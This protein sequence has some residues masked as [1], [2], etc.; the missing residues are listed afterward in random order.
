MY[1]LK[2]WA[3]RRGT[4]VDKYVDVDEFRTLYYAFM[5]VRS[6]RGHNLR[7][8]IGHNHDAEELQLFQGSRLEMYPEANQ[9][10]V[11]RWI[12][13]SNLEWDPYPLPEPEAE[14]VDTPVTGSIEDL[15]PMVVE[16][17]RRVDVAAHKLLRMYPP[18]TADEDD[19]TFQPVVSVMSDFYKVESSDITDTFLTL[20][21]EA[22][23]NVAEA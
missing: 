2:I 17:R 1:Y 10:L 20:C 13:L 12:P 3:T 23:N 9:E 6:H 22:Q 16:Y 18:T 11:F 21:A 19:L 4:H 15:D 8:Y 7:K 14:D 5:W